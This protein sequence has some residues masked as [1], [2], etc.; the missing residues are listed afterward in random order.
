MPVETITE[1]TRRHDQ[2]GPAIR[3]G[4]TLVFGD[5]AQLEVQ[6][7]PGVGHATAEPPANSETRLRFIREYWRG[8][9]DLAKETFNSVKN[10]LLGK[11]FNTPKW[12]TV[13]WGERPSAD[14]EMCLT[15]LRDIVS[16]EREKLQAVEKE[17]EQLPCVQQ[18]RKAQEAAEKERERIATVERE[19]RE[20]ILSIMI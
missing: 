17:Y 6:V 2:H 18:K 9:V 5:G 13:L 15:A 8:R 12:R 3:I 11:S 7:C 1:F 14:S 20:R 4:G 10:N 16:K 19:K